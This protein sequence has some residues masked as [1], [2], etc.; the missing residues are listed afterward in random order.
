MSF[1]GCFMI[2]ITKDREVELPKLKIGN[3]KRYRDKEGNLVFF[4]RGN[5]DQVYGK[6]AQFKIS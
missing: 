5:S 3:R 2:T 4:V 1:M 6:Y